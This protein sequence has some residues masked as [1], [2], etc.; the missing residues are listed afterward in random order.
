MRDECGSIDP[1]LTNPIITLPPNVLSTYVPPSYSIGS[2]YTDLNALNG[3]LGFV[4]QAK[5]LK[6]ADLQ[7]PTFGLGKETGVDGSVHMTVGP[8]W[9]PVII[10]PREVFTLDPVW[11]NL[12]TDLASYYVFES[13]AIFDPPIALTPASHLVAPPPAASSTKVKG[14]SHVPADPTVAYDPPA[15][16]L[17]DAADPP[18]YPRESELSP[19][20]SSRAPQ[21][22]P[23]NTAQPA[24]VPLDPTANP[25][26]A[27]EPARNPTP[28]S[29]D[30]DSTKAGSSGLKPSIF[31][32]LEKGDPQPSQSGNADP[33]HIVPVP[34]SDTKNMNVNGQILSTIP[35]DIHLSV[36]LHAPGGSAITL[37][38]SILS[39]VS[40]YPAQQATTLYKDH[41][42]NN[43]PSAPTVQIIADHEV[44]S[45]LFEVY[46]AGST[47]S[48]GGNA[49]TASNHIISL[50][51]AGTLVIDSSSIALSPTKTQ[52]SSPAN[53]KFDSISIQAEPSTAV[54]DGTAL[55]P[56][57][58]GTKIDGNSISLEQGGTLMIG[59]RRLVLPPAWEAAPSAFNLDGYTI[60]VESSVTLIDG[61]TLESGATGVSINENGVSLEQDKTLGIETSHF[62]LPT[63][64][65]ATRPGVFNLNGMTVQAQQSA[66]VVNGVTLAPGGPGTNINGSS[67]SL[68]SGGALDV[69]TGRFAIPTGSVNVTATLQTFEGSQGK[70]HQ[71]PGVLV[72][73]AVIV[74][75]LCVMMSG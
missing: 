23:A 61:V 46:V 34:E 11:A 32:A 18:N 31:S 13:F 30:D 51:P 56:G 45:N 7:C 71:K 63:A 69:G 72:S 52:E 15:T 67:V 54:I 33:T 65:Q 29:Q 5:P 3:P 1:I 50:S 59:T 41:S 4:G 40:N 58:P 17:P 12:C 35:S 16:G 64:A 8:P 57:G 28:E 53:L 21:K 2:T 22:S 24:A 6:I 44:V 38:D 26:T 14:P 62:A 47:L 36:V 37:S 27:P 25:T 66:V 74:V 10:P 73:A 39:L 75:G 70:A 49:I 9:L 42:M 60:Q 48:P 55:T 20:D 43:Q 68:E 19:V